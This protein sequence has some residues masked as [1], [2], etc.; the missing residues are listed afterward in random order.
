MMTWN[1]GK[2]IMLDCR[3][4]SD[5]LRTDHGVRGQNPLR[6]ARRVSAD[7]GA[8]DSCPFGMVPNRLHVCP[9]TGIPFGYDV[10]REWRLEAASLRG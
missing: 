7:A 4:V 8:G 9:P 6:A 1:P 5:Y 2:D 3:R 10:L